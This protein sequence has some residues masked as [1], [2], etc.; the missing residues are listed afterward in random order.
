MSDTR[1]ARTLFGDVV[2]DRALEQVVNGSCAR[3]VDALRADHQGD[4]RQLTDIASC[5]A[6]RCIDRFELLE[7]LGKGAMGEVFIA[8]EIGSGRRAALKTMHARFA[9]QADFVRR[10]QREATALANLRHPGLATALAIGHQTGAPWLAM[11]LIDGPGLDRVL[12]EHGK[13][14]EGMAL[15]VVR[16]VAEA[17]AHASAGAGLVHRDIKPGNLL[18]SRPGGRWTWPWCDGDQVKIIDFGLVK[19]GTG[20]DEA[21][22]LTGVAM[23]TPSYMAPEQINGDKGID[24]RV[25]CYALGATLYHLL[26]GA[27]PY[28]GTTPAATLSAHLRQPIP[29][30][31][32]QVPRLDQATRQLVQTAMAKQR[33]DRYASW[34]AF[35]IALRR[36]IDGL[37]QRAL[38]ATR[39]AARDHTSALERRTPVVGS[40]G[41]NLR[42]KSTSPV[43]QQTTGFIR[44]RP[45]STPSSILAAIET[46]PTSRIGDTLPFLLLAGCVLASIVVIACWH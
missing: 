38:P 43:N 17:L 37:R 42:R 3:L 16:Q 10:F 32:Q 39:N 44:R 15:S 19:R 18:L 34:D 2:V 7:P 12:H 23:G 28:S 9:D 5:S 20:Q 8:R 6:A 1:L 33:D 24:W 45:S 31:G 13:L 41:L 25:D 30:P 26:T 46:G 21:L 36:A 11:E 14:P 29:D 22:T 40:T 27:P 4:E 35:I